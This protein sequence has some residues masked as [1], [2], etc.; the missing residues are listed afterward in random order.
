MI[1]IKTYC[2]SEHELEFIKA[3]LVESDGFVDKVVVY[4]Y[5]VTHRGDS[6][7]FRLA[8]LLAELPPD[9]K[10]RLIYRPINID[11]ITVKT[12]DAKLIHE[13][14]EP[15][16]RSYFFNDSQFSIKRHDIIFDVDVDEIVYARYYPILIFAARYLP[17]PIGLKLNQ[18]FYR[19]N[20]LWRDANF[21]SPAVYRFGSIANKARVL[22]ETFKFF[23]QRDLKL[24]FPMRC[25]A[26]LS[27]IM[28]TEMMIRKL[29]SYSHP[30]YE[31]YA[32]TEVLE[33]AIKNKEY[34]FD[35]NRSFHIDELDWSDPRIP[36][37]F[38]VI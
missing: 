8:D 19:K 26:H 36:S 28:P 14:N 9:L 37:V 23:H 24:H 33:E 22:N 25:G 13:I 32:V 31:K 29:K 11:E 7:P 16:Q 21:K 6:K 27:W 35:T 30:E 5:N 4:E 3:Q 1:Y 20:Y 12:N 38:R 10:K 2:Y 34:V 18:F 17:I 15:I